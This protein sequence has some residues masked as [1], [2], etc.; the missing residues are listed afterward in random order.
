MY[1][2]SVK[3]NERTET[4]RYIIALI[5]CIRRMKINDQVDFGGYAKIYSYLLN[6]MKKNRLKKC[7]SY[8]PHT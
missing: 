8:T 1:F 4:G 6:R 3:L 2:Y 5:K 7:I